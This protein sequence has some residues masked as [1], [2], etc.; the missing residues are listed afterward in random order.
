MHITNWFNFLHFLVHGI[1][2]RKWFKKF[3]FWSLSVLDFC[4]S[5]YFR[6]APEVLQSGTGYNSKWAYTLMWCFKSKFKNLA[7]FARFLLQVVMLDFPSWWFK[8]CTHINNLCLSHILTEG[9]QVGSMGNTSMQLPSVKACLFA[10]QNSALLH[11][12]MTACLQVDCWIFF[13]V[14]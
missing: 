8:S 1:F 6:M 4:L 3:L 12:F 9:H 11:R 14:A 10:S 2:L 13:F 5:L 7:L